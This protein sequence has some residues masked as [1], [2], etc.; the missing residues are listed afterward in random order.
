MTAWKRKEVIG[1]ATLYLG[2]CL[3]ILPTLPKVDAVITDP[4]WPNVPDGMFGPCDPFSLLAS[5]A[6][7]WGD[8]KRVVI[9]MRTDS[10]PRFLCCIPDRYK[11]FRTSNL[12][13]SCPGH[14]GRKLGG[15]EHAYAFGDPI[16]SLVGQRVIPGEA[17]KAQPGDSDRRHPC[18]RSFTHMKFLVR[19]Y[20][21]CDEVILDPFM[22][23]GTTMLAADA[24]GR[25]SIGIEIEPKYFDIAC[26]RIENAQ[27]QERLFA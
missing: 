10:D 14:L 7:L 26:E 27:R 12:S 6:D 25:K 2:D 20:S 16:R 4:V 8:P 24:A 23:S 13:Y 1:N 17:P 3:E 19:W 5:A 22:G 15:L 11:F 9:V 21:E 18:P